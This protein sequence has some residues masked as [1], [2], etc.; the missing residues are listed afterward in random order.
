[1]QRQD[2]GSIVSAPCGVAQGIWRWALR[3]G[4]GDG[5]KDEGDASYQVGLLLQQP[6]LVLLGLQLLLPA[7]SALNKLSRP[8]VKLSSAAV[9]L[10]RFSAQY[11]VNR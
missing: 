9:M 3:G 8:C 1:M 11:A 4:E 10:Y 2:G 6:P 5:V 7:G